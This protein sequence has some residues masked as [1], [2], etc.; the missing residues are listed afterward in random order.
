MGLG[1]DFV[2]PLSQQE[3]QQEEQEP[4]QN[5]TE[6]LKFGTRT[7]LSIINS[8]IKKE[9]QPKIFSDQKCFQPNFFRPK[10]FFNLKFSTKIFFDQI[11]F[12]D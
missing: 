7:Y 1:V 9:I 2:L 5:L 8:L 12:F 3:Q 4:L 10:F 11:Y 6:G